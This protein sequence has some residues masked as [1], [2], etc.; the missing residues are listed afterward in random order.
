MPAQRTAPQ[1]PA[2]AA[3]IGAASRPC[4]C[5]AR[6][7]FAEAARR[8]RPSEAALLGALLEILPGDPRLALELIDGLRAARVTP[9]PQP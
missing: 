8:R 3:A 5:P 7:P 4:L 9:E 1:P 6:C 2:G